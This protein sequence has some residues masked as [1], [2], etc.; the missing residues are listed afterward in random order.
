MARP[1]SELTKF[2]LSLPADLPVQEVIEKA[3]EKGFTSTESNVHRV[4]T[5]VKRAAEV[6]P[7]ASAD[8]VATM[9]AT[10]AKTVLTNSDV[11][12]ALRAKRAANG[13]K[14]AKATS[15]TTTRPAAARAT[16]AK[17]AAG[18]KTRTART[19]GAG[20]SKSDFIRAQPAN[21][22][23]AEVVAKAKA[24]GIKLDPYLV[25]KVRGR[26]NTDKQTAS[27]PAKSTKKTTSSAPRTQH[28]TRAAPPTASSLGS[29][30]ELLR[31]L[32]SEIG[33][34]RAID[35][36]EEQRRRVLRILGG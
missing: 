3:K 26:L 1:Q 4:R 17:K 12:R 22:T 8:A 5:Q 29:A 33:L 27:P 7:T 13:A 28:P 18:S 32:A 2:I 35:L 25:Y 24:T 15:T 11:V 31:A 21:L 19:N 9:A 23:A 10:T 6:P 30:E 16:S 14:P 34:A 36:L 20:L